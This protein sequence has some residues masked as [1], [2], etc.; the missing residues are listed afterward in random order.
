MNWEDWGQLLFFTY[1]SLSITYQVVTDLKVKKNNDQ[2]FELAVK[3]GFL[4]WV[5]FDGKSDRPDFWFFYLF[6][7][8]GSLYFQWVDWMADVS[9]TLDGA[10][11]YSFWDPWL[12]P[13]IFTL[14]IAI[15]T[16]AVG[17]RRLHEVGKS[18]WWQLLMITII[19]IIPLI[20][21]WAQPGGKSY[22]P[23]SKS[24]RSLSMTEELKELKEL[25]KEGS[26]TKAE[27]EKAKKK[28]LK[29]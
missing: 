21:W 22:P 15:P 27:F 7:I 29:D 3:N 16:L 19:G 4:K 13:N 10:K 23:K 24:R 28:L 11:G 18:G 20:I 25:Y 8:I 9:Q 5:D 2:D 12:L 6:T 26:I 14:L 1:L 17:A